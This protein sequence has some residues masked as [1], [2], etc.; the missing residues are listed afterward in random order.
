M[1]TKKA[2]AKRN[3]GHAPIAKK[4]EKAAGE[5]ALD[6]GKAWDYAPAPES[7]DHVKLKSRYELFIGGKWV[8]PQS[9]K[10]FDTISPSTEEKI[11]E[12]AEADAADV[13][14][15]GVPPRRAYQKNLA[16]MPRAQRGEY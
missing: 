15:A 3:G 2:L 1:S 16:K 9:K 13:D 6:F 7:P 12:I 5:H 8:K 11:A 14:A 4:T 10:Y